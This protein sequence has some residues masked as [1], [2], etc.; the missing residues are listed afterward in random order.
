MFGVTLLMTVN[1]N[2]FQR[3][4]QLYAAVVLS[5]IFLTVTLARLSHESYIILQVRRYYL[6]ALLFIPVLFFRIV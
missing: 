5:L 6:G 3:S 1:W 4:L 2:A